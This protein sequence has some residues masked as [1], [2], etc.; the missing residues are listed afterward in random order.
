M[1]RREEY[2]VTKSPDTVHLDEAHTVKRSLDE[3]LEGEGS[4]SLRVNLADALTT[5]GD[6]QAAMVRLDRYLS[7][8]HTPFADISLLSNAPRF[9][10]MLVTVLS[11]SEFLTDIVCRNPEFMTWLWQEVDLAVSRPRDE[12]THDLFRQVAGVDT[13]DARCRVMR[14]FKRREIL[15]IAT[16]DVF[17]HADLQ[18]IL[19][20][21]THLAESTLEAAIESAHRELEPRHGTPMTA[22]GEPAS[23]VVLG[24]GKL[25]GRE[26]N[27]S[28]DIDLIFLYSEDGETTGG[29][30]R[31]VTNGEYYH[32]LGERI[33]KAMSDITAEGNVFRVDMR[34]RPHGRTAPLA[35]TVASAFDYFERT[36]QAWERQALIKCRPVAGDRALGEAFV[37]H[38]RPFV[39]PRFFDDETLEDIRAMKQQMEKIISAR[40]ETETEVKLGK[41]GIRDIEFTVQM[42]QLLNG[43]RYEELR[44]GNTLQVIDA[45]GQ[46]NLLSPFEAT[47]LASNYTF[48][49]QVEHRLQIEGSQ[50]RHALPDSPRQLDTFARLFGYESGPAFMVEYGD[51]ADETRFIL[52][53]FLATKGAG[54]L[55]VNDLLNPHSEAEVGLKRLEEI[56]FTDTGA[57]RKELLHLACGTADRSHS[58]H[59]RQAFGV[60]A[61]NLLKALAETANPDA[62]LVQLSRILGGLKAP[63]SV[64]DILKWNPDFTK[65]LVGLVE[66]SPYLSEFII[67]DPGL[68]DVFGRAGAL[69]HA[70]RREDLERELDALVSAADPDAAPYR[71]HTGETFRIGVRDVF[72]GITVFDVGAELTQLA[73]VILQ[74][75]LKLARVKVA[76]RFGPSD[77]PF[78]V[79]ALGKLAAHEMGYGSDLDLIFVYDNEVEIESGADPLEY[80][81]AVAATTLNLLKERTRHGVLYDVDPRLRP[82][83][84]KGSLAVSVNR[85]R[86]Y[87]TE[88]AQAWE[89]LALLKVRAVAG[90]EGFAELVEAQ[91]RALA[92]ALP[93]TRQNLENI[94]NIRTKMAASASPLHLKKCEGGIAELEFA[95]RLL[96]IRHAPEHPELV[97]GD[98]LGALRRLSELN[99]ISADDHAFL[100]ETYTFYRRIENRIRLEHG[101]STSTL[102]EN[103]DA[104]A[105]LAKRLGLEGDLVAM[106]EEKKKRVHELY[107]QTIIGLTHA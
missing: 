107:Q 98:V 36:G 72:H 29:R 85:L 9:A 35:V 57:A 15:R 49:R 80:F 5:C 87:Y 73:D 106:V 53:K 2:G 61:P 71:L 100:E 26:L 56:G 91:A 16:R 54:N 25:G 103:E 8:S 6:P 42:L 82:D 11:Q 90:D 79:L 77:A 41:G 34:L 63:A 67:R 96:Q 69:G 83:G 52:E 30:D 102:P 3:I 21:L 76:A 65:Y 31:S 32:K 19:D 95:I 37:T 39:F 84:G 45:L 51:R 68:F 99:L 38:T 7:A 4:E 14:R 10:R 55:W 18:S 101:R 24:M 70:A 23:F 33:I 66:N 1:G 43:G 28:S 88:Q 13:F 47:T 105:N 94:E 40:G 93:L 48:L 17:Q 78:A 104:R 20:D 58:L 64:Y 59:V 44:S 75:V 81:T 27:F 97:R 74:H 22:S 86:G 62:T 60:I 46:L 89:R 92:F 50:Q 12:M